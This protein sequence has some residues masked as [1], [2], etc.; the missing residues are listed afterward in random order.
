[1]LDAFSGDG[2]PVHLLTSEAFDIYQKQLKPKGV[3]AVHVSNRHLDL[4]PVLQAQAERLGQQTLT[5]VKYSDDTGAAHSEWVLMSRDA[6]LLG[7]PELAKR[8]V[9]NDGRKVLWTDARS[10]LMAILMKRE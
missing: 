5:V 6:E 1:M 4:K 8:S 9:V 2:V 7:H 3:I 10:D